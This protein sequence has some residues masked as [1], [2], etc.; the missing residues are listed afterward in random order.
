VTE[1][2]EITCGFLRGGSDVRVRIVNIDGSFTD[3]TVPDGHLLASLAVQG[4]EMLKSLFK[5]GMISWGEADLPVNHPVLGHVQHLK[6]SAE[7]EALL[8]EMG[9]K[10]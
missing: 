10:Y 5:S 1:G 3:V 6:D 4:E 8:D 7:V 2:A 9:I